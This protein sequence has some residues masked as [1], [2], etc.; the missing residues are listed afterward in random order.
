MRG[1][2]T[3]QLNLPISYAYIY[4]LGEMDEVYTKQNYTNEVVKETHKHLLFMTYKL[5][6]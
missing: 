3:G 5:K 1:Y 2:W 4:F 6:D